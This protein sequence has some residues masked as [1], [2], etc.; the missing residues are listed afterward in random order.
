MSA[1]Y[2]LVGGGDFSLLEA[3]GAR[4]SHRGT[5]V[6]EW[7]PA[8]GV[9]LGQRCQQTSPVWTEHDGLSLVADATLFNAQ[10]IEA[11]LA[12]R[13]R[14]CPSQ[15]ALEVIQLAF[16]EYGPACLAM[17]NSDFVIAWWNTR[18]K[19][20]ILAR[21]AFG[22]RILYYWQGPDYIAFASEYKALLTLTDLQARPYLEALQYLQ[23]TK[24][25]PPGHTLLHGVRSVP[26]AHWLEIHERHIVAHRY[27]D[28]VLNPQPIPLGVAEQ[29]LREL[30][31][32]AVRR[33]IAGE[34]ALG[35]ELSGG[36]D[37]TAVVTAIRL[38]RPEYP[39]KTFTVGAGPE[40]PEILRA[41]FVAEHMQTEHHEVFV[42]P[43][44]LPE[45]F[46]VVVWHLE[47][48]IA[49]TETVL[50]YQ[51]MKSAAAF[52][53]V[54]LGGYASDGLYGGMPKHKLI[55]LMQIT[56]IGR[57]VIE[58][59]Y[60]YTQVSEVPRSWLGKMAKWLYF[61]GAES[62]APAIRGAVQPLPSPPL[63]GHGADLLNHVLREGVL[64]GIP[65]WMPKVEKTHAAHGVEL[66]SPF[67]DL[68]LAR[69]SFELPGHFKLRG[70][71]DKYILRRA[72]LPLL[73][74]NIVRHPKF[75]QRM[76][77]SLQ[78]SN[79]LDALA[80]QLLSPQALRQR[81]FFKPA[82]VEALRRRAPGKPYGFNRAMRLWTTIGTELW[83]RQFL[84]HR[85]ARPMLPAHNGSRTG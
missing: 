76:H 85:G 80:D 66:R 24:Y 32:N 7:S 21:D 51:L 82:E 54:V 16:E 46:P 65:S 27:W 61:G 34:P 9:F 20:L 33:R 43:E 45:V 75:P 70:L 19:R 57:G 41:R 55:K 37:S 22:L 4:L 67:T 39:L 62:P 58:E 47:D 83:A 18:T 71:R 52:I 13:G 48:P 35:A 49:R 50:Y 1:I 14:R 63:S 11:Q 25:L 2:G 60:H 81:G 79:M 64:Y 59:F 44:C 72:L 8:A 23:R 12:S 15:S 5:V 36:I 31:L 17:F 74:S 28:V 3:M 68:E 40:D 42:G 73:P 78:L 84:D 30:F 26:A 38:A 53:N 10:E 56:P 6:R 77:Y 29:R 69:F